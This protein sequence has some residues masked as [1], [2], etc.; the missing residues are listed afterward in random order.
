LLQSVEKI[1]FGL[2]VASIDISTGGNVVSQTQT[3][4]RVGISLIN[5]LVKGYEFFKA[6]LW[7]MSRLVSRLAPQL[8]V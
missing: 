2:P 3:L 1:T 7:E 8:S 6:A 5:K 4:L